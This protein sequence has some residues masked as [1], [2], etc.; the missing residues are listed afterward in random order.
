MWRTPMIQ[1]LLDE[2]FGVLSSVHDSSQLLKHR[3]FSYQKARFVS[4]HKDPTER[5]E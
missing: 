5:Q 3:G 4:D 1:H 2:R